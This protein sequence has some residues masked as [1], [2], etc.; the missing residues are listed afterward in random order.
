MLDNIALVLVPS[1]HLAKRISL[2]GIL[3][4]LEL[5]CLANTVAT[6]VFIIG[7]CGLKV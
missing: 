4:D 3:S 1:G 5:V 2:L 6:D 7:D